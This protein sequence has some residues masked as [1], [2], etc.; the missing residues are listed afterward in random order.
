[1]VQGLDVCATCGGSMQASP[2]LWFC[3]QGCQLYWASDSTDVTMLRVLKDANVDRVR[4]GGKPSEVPAA[5][6][7]GWYAVMQAR[8]QAASQAPEGSAA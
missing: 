8:A 1:M 7:P 2:S 6:V 5:A 4:R 3:S